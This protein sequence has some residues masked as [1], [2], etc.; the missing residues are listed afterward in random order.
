[1]G[2]RKGIYEDCIDL[3]KD[4]QK[5]IFTVPTRGLIGLRSEILND[6]KGTGVVHQ[7]FIG[8]HEYRGP[9]KK[10]LKGAIISTAT[11]NC[12]AY[13]LEDIQKFG[14]LFVRPGA[15]VYPGMVIG[16]NR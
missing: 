2:V 14:Q 9:L 11:G 1:M 4:R 6:T 8:Y 3:G 10:N 12:T 16:E 5:L 7:T 13:A 15:K